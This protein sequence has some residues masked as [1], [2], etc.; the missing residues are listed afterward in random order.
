MLPGLTVEGTIKR[1]GRAEGFAGQLECDCPYNTEPLASY[2]K[3]GWRL[4]HRDRIEE[5]ERGS[6]PENK[7][8]QMTASSPKIL[9]ASARTNRRK[10]A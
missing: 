10:T 6:H 3:A 5:L 1:K 9:E 2:W 8:G 4:G 7:A